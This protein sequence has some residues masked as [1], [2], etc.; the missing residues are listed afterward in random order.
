MV[1]SG[2]EEA[3]SERE[4]RG[5]VEEAEEGG[6]GCVGSGR[7]SKA[8]IVEGQDAEVSW[9]KGRM[10]DDDEAEGDEEGGEDDSENENEASFNLLQ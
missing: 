5:H 2:G 1:S 8:A 9:N 7:G 3:E 6:E 4:G 10:G